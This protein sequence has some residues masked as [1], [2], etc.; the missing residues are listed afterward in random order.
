[1]HGGGAAFLFLGLW[2]LLAP[3]RWGR[4][5]LERAALPLTAAFLIWHALVY[6]ATAIGPELVSA[7]PEVEQSLP[8]L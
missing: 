7:L 4:H 2:V 5:A 6:C 3:E 8:C 1:M